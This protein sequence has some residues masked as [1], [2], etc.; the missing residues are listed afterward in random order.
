MSSCQYGGFVNGRI[1]KN[2][3]EHEMDGRI[4]LLLVACRLWQEGT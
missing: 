1:R 4:S 3:I 2:E